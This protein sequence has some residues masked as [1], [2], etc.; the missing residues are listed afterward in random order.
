M[1]DLRLWIVPEEAKRLQRE[2]DDAEWNDD[3]RLAQ[4]TRELL[5]FKRL[6]QKGVLYEPKF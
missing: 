2:C 3:A 1:D 4:L 5:H 6:E